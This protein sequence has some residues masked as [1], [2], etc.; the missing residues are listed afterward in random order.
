MPNLHVLSRKVAGLLPFLLVAALAACTEEKIVE[1]ERPPFNPPADAS[2]GFLGYY[3][4][5]EQQTTCGNCHADYQAEWAETGHAEAYATLKANA[6]AQSFC[7]S[8]H[9]VN[10]RGNTS[11]GTVGWD[12]VQDSTYQDVQCEACHG[13]GQQHVEGV[14][15]GTVVRPQPLLGVGIKSDDG[16]IKKTA[17]TASSCA[18]CHNGTH[19]P[20]VEQ[21]IQSRHALVRQGEV[22]RTAPNT[23]AGCHEGRGFL[24]KNN[25]K[26]TWK[27]GEYKETDPMEKMQPTTCVVCHDPHDA[28][29]RFQLRYPINVADET[30]NLC[31][32][33]HNNR[34]QPTNTNSGPHGP[35]GGVLLGYAGYRTPNFV[36]DTARIYGSHA[37]PT[38]NAELCAGCHVQRQTINAANGAFQLQSVGHLFKPIPC[39]DAQGNPTSDDSCA[40]NSTARSWNACVKSGCHATATVAANAFTAARLEVQAL[41]DILFKNLA[42]G[43]SGSTGPNLDPYPTDD[44]YLPRI[45][46]AFPALWQT[47]TSITP[48]EGCEFNVR[49]VAEGLAGHPDGSKGTH[50]AFLARALLSSCISY[51]KEQYPT[52]LPAIP[53]E[54]SAIVNKYSG[55]APAGFTVRRVPLPSA[56]Q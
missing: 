41:A 14:N 5:G 25:V 40:F 38:A 32:K 11:T 13:P 56:D 52:I 49:V 16:V 26:A 10:E 55:T 27:E 50:N 19:H 54:V 3:T 9:T 37:S 15:A 28:T 12:K 6:G 24:K 8:C 31:I 39:L 30:Q 20:F 33:C 2:S 22:Q 45:K 21:W 23:C 53:A 18:S 36:Y 43:S 7:Y 44:G 4:V 48:P 42:G 34:A 47:T 46:A 51:L 1:V 35:Q 17:D 29:N